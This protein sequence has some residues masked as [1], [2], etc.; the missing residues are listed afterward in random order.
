MIHKLLR[1]GI[2][3]TILCGFLALPAQAQDETRI[4]QAVAFLTDNHIPST[5]YAELAAAPDYPQIETV[6]AKYGYSQER[7]KA[8]VNDM[9]LLLLDNALNP[10]PSQDMHVQ[11]LILLQSYGLNGRDLQQLGPRANDPAAMIEYLKQRGLTQEQAEQCLR[12]LISLAQSAIDQGLS[13]YYVI[14]RSLYQIVEDADLPLSI[15]WD[16]AW[17]LN[18]PAAAADY[19]TGI[20]YTADQ[21]QTFAGL[22]PQLVGNGA[23]ADLIDGWNIRSLIFRL[24]GMGLPPQAI[25]EVVELGNRD[26]FRGYLTAKGLSGDVLE[27]AVVQIVNCV[28]SQGQTLSPQR[29]QAFQIREA[30]ALLSSAGIPSVTW[31]IILALNSHPAA[32][33]AYLAETYS[34]DQS[35]IDAFAKGLSQS[36]FVR[37]LDPDNADDYL[38]GTVGQAETE[39]AL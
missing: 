31:S 20:G 17:L 16:S 29:L 6:L 34:L 33:D 8:F 30:Q 3:F 36:T 39:V 22:I 7:L 38:S 21:V 28:G 15:L 10:E 25:Y 9:N 18:D 13:K 19:L 26:A 12:Q 5:A 23:T 11:E 24:E 2:L 32:L 35:Q 27:L 14:N 1:Y 4:E 37:T